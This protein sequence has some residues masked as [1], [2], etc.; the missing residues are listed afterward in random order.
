ML[1]T[2]MKTH[3]HFNTLLLPLIW[4]WRGLLSSTPLPCSLP[5]LQKKY[6]WCLSITNLWYKT[7][8]NVIYTSLF[9]T[10]RHLLAAGTREPCSAPPN[11]GEERVLVPVGV[12]AA[13][14]TWPDHTYSYAKTHLHLVVQLIACC[15]GLIK[16]QIYFINQHKLFLPKEELAEALLTSS[17]QFHAHGCFQRFPGHEMTH[18]KK[19]WWLEGSCIPCVYWCRIDGIPH[20][21][22]TIDQNGLQCGCSIVYTM[23]LV[24]IAAS[25]IR[26]YEKQ[27]TKNSFFK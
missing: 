14:D 26:L 7:I 9:P 16:L 17:L 27:R 13:W 20:G 5:Q 4:P 10:C 19:W 3:S 15:T 6:N 25:P 1:V 24:S 23:Y 12:P 11:R 21:W 22:D 18:T 2:Y 8:P